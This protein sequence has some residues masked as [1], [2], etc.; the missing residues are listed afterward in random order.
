MG[1]SKQ[2]KG[3]YYLFSAEW[4]GKINISNK[5]RYTETLSSF[6]FKRKEKKK[7]IWNFMSF[8]K[9]NRRKSDSLHSL[10]NM[11]TKNVSHNYGANVCPNNQIWINLSVPLPKHLR[12]VRNPISL[13]QADQTNRPI[14]STVV[15]WVRK[16]LSCEHSLGMGFPWRGSKSGRVAMAINVVPWC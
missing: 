13:S 2:K 4:C 11:K 15:I 10:I 7:W 6:F 14:K 8:V 1:C 9:E 3:V 5:S 16:T 12:N